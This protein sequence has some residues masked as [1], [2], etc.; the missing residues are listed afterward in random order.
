MSYLISSAMKVTEHELG[1]D[2]QKPSRQD[3]VEG[4]QAS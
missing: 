4:R 3:N 2:R 1:M